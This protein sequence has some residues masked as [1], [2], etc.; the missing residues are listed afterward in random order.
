MIAYDLECSKGHG[1]EGWFENSESFEVQKNN[2]M[3]SCPL[4]EDTDVRR[5]LSPVAVRTVTESGERAP[6]RDIDY[7]KL[8]K[9]LID[10]VNNDFED[11]GANFTKEALKMHYDVTE[12]KNIR[13]TA[14]K[15]ETKMLE[16]EGVQFFRLPV[17]KADD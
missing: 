8:A 17:K 16:D 14:T 10:Q 12:K 4:C 3:I 15:N 7:K 9:E 2:N 13:G 1:F 11:V 6:A 5:L